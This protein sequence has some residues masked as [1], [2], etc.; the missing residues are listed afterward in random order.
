VIP[1][2]AEV[3]GTYGADFYA[4]TPAVTRHAFG[5]GRGWYVATALDFDGVAWVIRRVLE[6]HGLAGPYPDVPDLETAARVSPDG[7]RLL[8]LLNHRAHAIEVTACASGL[9]LLSGARVADGEPIRLEPYGVM[10]L[11]QDDVRGS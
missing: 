6:E 9:E 3:I 5:L 1:V 7:A 10:V 2:G 4:G 11:R 8:F